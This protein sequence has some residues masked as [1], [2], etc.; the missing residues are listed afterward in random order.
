M[1]TT[2]TTTS[3]THLQTPFP[4]PFPVAS[5]FDPYGK[6]ILCCS[7]G[8]YNNMYKGEPYAWVTSITS[9]SNFNYR[10]VLIL[11]WRFC[12]ARIAPLHN[13]HVFI[14]YREVFSRKVEGKL[15]TK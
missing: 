9:A 15:L 13:S 12:V 2:S 4:T 6:V 3:S 10:H 11:N 5:D 8:I 14:K 7:G 1:C